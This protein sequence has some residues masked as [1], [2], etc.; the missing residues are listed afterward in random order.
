[1]CGSGSTAGG[2]GSIVLGTN[3]VGLLP[4]TV[5]VDA[6]VVKNLTASE[7]SALTPTNGMIVYD[8]T[9]NKFKG[10]ENGDW[11]DLI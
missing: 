6:L 8:T 4:R 2:S 10:Y 11:E 3:I 5:Y 1:V 7:I 9:N